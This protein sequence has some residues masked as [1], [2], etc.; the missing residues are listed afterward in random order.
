[1]VVV[2][3][4]KSRFFSD[5]EIRWDVGTIYFESENN[6]K[7]KSIAKLRNIATYATF[8]S[9]TLRRYSNPRSDYY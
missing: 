8:A 4:E 3:G 9:V 1:M 2:E 7:L 6:C 5:I